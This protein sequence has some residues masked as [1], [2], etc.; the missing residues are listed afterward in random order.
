MADVMNA[1]H[2]GRRGEYKSI[3]FLE[4][5]GYSCI[6]SAASK[7]VFDLVAVNGDHV[8][9]IQCKV[10]RWPGA[11]ELRAIANFATPATCRKI[12]HRWRDGQAAP[13]VKEIE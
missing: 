13:D 11:D 8:L 12:I 10:N 4:A 9:L 1:V 6:R 2:K 3:R 5:A 7:G